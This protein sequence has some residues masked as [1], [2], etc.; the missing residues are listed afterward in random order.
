MMLPVLFLKGPC[1]QKML[2]RGLLAQLPNPH[3]FIGSSELSHHSRRM[4]SRVVRSEFLRP[5]CLSC[6]AACAYGI[7]HVSIGQS[8][9]S[10]RAGQLTR[11]PRR[12]C[13]DSVQ[14]EDGG[15]FRKDKNPPEESHRN[16]TR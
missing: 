3:T 10:H 14:Q 5:L 4:A 7:G 15:S 11:L 13:P 2:K 1:S 6:R 9:H 8:M 12:G 16:K